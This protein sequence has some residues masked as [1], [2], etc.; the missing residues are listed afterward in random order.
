M[1]PCMRLDGE[2][3]FGGGRDNM[4]RLEDRTSWQADVWFEPDLVGG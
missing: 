2:I 4:D 1:I 3:A